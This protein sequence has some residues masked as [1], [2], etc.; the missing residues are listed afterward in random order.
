MLKPR[1]YHVGNAGSPLITEEWPNLWQAYAGHSRIV[2]SMDRSHGNGRRENRTI[3]P[4]G[5]WFT[6]PHA[7]PSLCEL[8]HRIERLPTYQQE[9][10]LRPNT[11]HLADNPCCPMWSL[12]NLVAALLHKISCHEITPSDAQLVGQLLS[13]CLPAFRNGTL[14][15]SCWDR[16]GSDPRLLCPLVEPVRCLRSPLIPFILATSLPDQSPQAD[17]WRTTLFQLP[18]RQANSLAIWL[19]LEELEH[20]GNLTHGLQVPIHMLVSKRL[21]SSFLEDMTS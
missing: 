21:F 12:P 14:K 18:V 19:E 9:C 15:R 4:G 6:N 3:I 13:D 1:P 17:S 10:L 11:S 5:T 16:Y 8:Q 7:L 2:F 20:S